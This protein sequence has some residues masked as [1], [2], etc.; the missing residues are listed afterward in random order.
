MKK[1][2]KTSFNVENT[3]EMYA[4]SFSISGSFDDAYDSSSEH[5]N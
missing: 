3:L 4:C 1:L 2:K 5:S